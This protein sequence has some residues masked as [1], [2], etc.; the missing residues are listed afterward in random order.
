MKLSEL[1]NGGTQHI[2]LDNACKKILKKY[3]SNPVC[4]YSV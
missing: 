1:D 2:F 4:H 3:S